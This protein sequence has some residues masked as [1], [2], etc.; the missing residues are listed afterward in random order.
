MFTPSSRFQLS[1]AAMMLLS[2]FIFF[3]PA[4]TAW[5]DGQNTIYYID[6]NYQRVVADLLFL[7]H[8]SV[9]IAAVITAF[10]RLVGNLYRPGIVDHRQM[11]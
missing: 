6:K 11:L 1:H 7:I 5:A 2:A 3:I 8:H 4:H 10:K 9:V